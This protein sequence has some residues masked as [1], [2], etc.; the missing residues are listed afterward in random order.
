[1]GYVK[2]NLMENEELIYETNVH[3]IYFL[4]PFISF[5][6]LLGS[7]YLVCGDGEDQILSCE[8]KNYITYTLFFLFLVDF[9]ITFIG[10][11]STEFAVTS[12]RIIIKKGFIK[13]KTWELLLSKVETI[14][15]DQGIIGR[16]L[17]FGTITV[18]GT[19]G[20]SEPEK[21]IRRPLEFRMKAQEQVEKT[22][23]I[24]ESSMKKEN[25]KE[26]NNYENNIE[27]KLSE[28]K[29]LKDKNL[30][31]DEEHDIKRQEILS[32]F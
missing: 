4:S 11:I 30:I 3:I 5:L 25:T 10:Y 23:S 29:N 8:H 13:R 32:R 15:V 27:S 22:Q 12:K 31:S 28:I 24:T 2:K 21:R 16:I 19:G 20:A 9:L 18:S 6:L 26:K 7:Y 14:Q 1:M 17:R